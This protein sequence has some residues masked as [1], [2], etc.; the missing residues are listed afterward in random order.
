MPNETLARRYAT[1]IFQ[2]ATEANAVPAVGQ[3]PAHV[4]R[5]ARR[6]RRREPV[7]PLARR[8]PQREV[9]RDRARRSLSCTTS[10]CT[11]FCCSSRSAAKRSRPR[12][13]RSTTSSSGKRAARRRCNVTSARPLA[14]ADLDALVA[15]LSASIQNA[16]RRRAERRSRVDRRRSHHDGR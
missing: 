9:R 6:R 7:L 4:R 16:V 10:R 11:R 3:R 14:K 13:S 2:L 5:G 12:S 8:R 15:K 1:A